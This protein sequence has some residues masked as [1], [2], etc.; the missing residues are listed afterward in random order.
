M[1]F[2]GLNEA[3]IVTG[4]WFVGFLGDAFE[5]LFVYK[6]GNMCLERLQKGLAELSIIGG[7]GLQSIVPDLG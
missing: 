6:C 5:G 7:L 1:L 3:G 2:S 4:G